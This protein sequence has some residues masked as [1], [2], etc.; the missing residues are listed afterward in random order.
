VLTSVIRAPLVSNCLVA[1]YA[2]RCTRHKTRAHGGFVHFEAGDTVAAI[3]RLK[4]I[5]AA[6]GYP[7]VPGHEPNAWPALTLQLT[8]SRV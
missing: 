1:S 4:A 7:V 2:Q 6:R 8:G 3:R 5:G